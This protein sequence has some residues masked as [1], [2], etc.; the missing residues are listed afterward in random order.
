MWVTFDDSQ[1][2]PVGPIWVEQIDA[3][4][5]RVRSNFIAVRIMHDG[6]MALF[7]AGRYLDRID[8][9]S[10]PGQGTAFTIK[11]PLTLAIVSALVVQA[12]GERFAIPQISVMELVRVGRP[13]EAD[14]ES[15]IERISETPV[16]RLRDRLLPLVS[17]AGLLGL[18]GSEEA[19]IIVVAQVGSSLLGIIV[20]RV[21][22]TEEIVVKPVAPML[23]QLTVFSC[24]TILGDGSV[25]MIL[26]PA[27]IARA[28]GIGA[29]EDHRREPASASEDMASGEREAMLLFRAGDTR[30]MAV[31][32]SRVARLEQIPRERIELS[33]SV[34]VG[35]IGAVDAARGPVR[36]A[37]RAVCPAYAAG[38]R[39][40]RWRPQRGSY[41][42]RDRGRGGGPAPP[43]AVCHEAWRSRHGGDQWAG[44]RRDRH[45]LL[46]GATARRA[47]RVVAEGGRSVSA[48]LLDRSAGVR[49]DRERQFVALTVAEQLCGVPVLGVRDI[50]AQQTITRIPLA[51]PE[52]AGS[53]NLRGRI[54]TAIDLRRRLRLPPAPP[55]A[56]TMSV[57][58]EQEGELY[59]LLVQVCEVMR[60]PAEGFERNP[61]TLPPV[62]AAYSNGIYRLDGMLLVVLDVARLLAVRAEPG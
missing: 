5:A 2:E 60:L 11:I 18:A 29:G 15:V 43:R 62:W 57:V 23:R 35:S 55:G 44:D 56:P 1:N 36:R 26:D 50:L 27:G 3:T 16:L 20:D 46:A 10:Q 34:P 25:I 41:G 9:T 8:L 7:A 4:V 13:G 54:V 40:R 22:D 38:A 17:L 42:R 49:D 51:P 48:A 45:G 19:G 6:E 47:P 24:N 53:L 59:A 52:V 21:F 31:P 30:P 33:A 32:L 37:R 12:G 58:T 61:P 14:A 28:A 39:L